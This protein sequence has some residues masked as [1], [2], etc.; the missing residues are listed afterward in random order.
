MVLVA[1]AALRHRHRASRAPRWASRC[2]SSPRRCVDGPDKDANV[3][4]RS[5]DSDGTPACEVRVPRL[6][7]HL[8]PVGQAGRDLVPVPARRGLR[9]AVRPARAGAARVPAIRSTSSACSSS[10]TA[11][12]S[13]DVVDE[14]R[15]ALPAGRRPRRRDH[16]PLRGRRL[17]HDR[18]RRARRQGARDPHRRPRRAPS[19]ATR[20]GRLRP[21]T[22]RPDAAAAAGSAPEVADEFPELGL[23]VAEVEARGGRSLAARCASGCACCPTA[24]PARGRS[25]CARSRCPWAYRVFFRQVGHRPRRAAHAD[26]ADRDRP[27][28]PRRLQVARAGARTRC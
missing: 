24:S 22:R 8:R 9:A 4:P 15:L 5:S 1:P 28:D 14:A 13:R 12:R 27:A 2:R 25:R 3:V 19:C 16:Q 23:V 20:F 21:V 26:R 17:P 10:A 7:Q 18:V 6:A 11:T